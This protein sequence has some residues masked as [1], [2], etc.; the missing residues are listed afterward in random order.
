MSHSAIGVDLGGTFIKAAR[1]SP[2]SGILHQLSGET[3]A[4]LG[5]RVVLDRIAEMVSFLL[6]NVE[7]PAVSG[8]GIGTPGSVDWDRTS[9]KRPPNFPG[10][11][12]VHFGRELESRLGRSFRTVVEN[13]ANVA[14]LGSAHYG[15][16]KPFSSFIMITLGT[17]VGGAIIYENRIFRGST[18][19][20]G[21][22][23]HMTIDYE[24]PFARSGIA[25]AV[26]AYLG[27][28]FLSRYARYRLMNQ[29]DSLV[30]K[31]SQDRLRDLTPSL[32]YEAAVQGDAGARDVFAWAGHKL[33]C[34]L[35]SAVNL[36]DIR[37]IV[38]GGGISAAGDLI[39]EP[40]RRSIVRYVT[41][42][43]LDDVEIIQEPGGNE[44][45][46]LGAAHLVF[47]SLDYE[48]DDHQD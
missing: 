1:V 8:I 5:P 31:L 7:G 45:G 40:A 10:W 36:L 12:V 25:G 13:D 46:L 19:G 14:A 30:H 42:G 22:I 33:G 27:Q 43:L 6:D 28:H 34:A 29:R 17:G 35:G 20:A 9:V 32:L 16:G 11:E 24:G 4:E 44:M 37:K 3:G 21:E 15:A 48:P 41:P 26:E 47:E 2:E 23:G 38:V 39:L 18:G